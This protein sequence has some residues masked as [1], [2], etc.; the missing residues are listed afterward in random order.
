[1]SAKFCRNVFPNLLEKRN[2]TAGIQSI[3]RNL[4]ELFFFLVQGRG[5]LGNIY[6]WATGNGGLT[7]DDCNCDG[8]TTSIYTVSIGCIGDHGLSAY[9]TELCSST[10]AVTFNG[11]A[12]REKEENKMVC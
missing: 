10:L 5:G 12:H 9:Y 8:Y 6:V 7:D 4:S 1:M 2:L 11:G 3:E